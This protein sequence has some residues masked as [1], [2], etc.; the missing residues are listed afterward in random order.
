MEKIYVF[1]IVCEAVFHASLPITS[2]SV[3]VNQCFCQLQV[4]Q[5]GI[6][7]FLVYLIR[8]GSDHS[9]ILLY[10]CL[11]S[12]RLQC[13][14]SIYRRKRSSIS[15]IS[16]EHHSSGRPITLYCFFDD[17]LDNMMK[18]TLQFTLLGDWDCTGNLI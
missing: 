13:A 11:G 3:V 18:S 15:G 4:F 10:V 17:F 12:I 2:P 9:E 7:T 6:D 1:H 16:L 14:P 8:I 5:L